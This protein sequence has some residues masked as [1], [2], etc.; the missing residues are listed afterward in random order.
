MSAYIK[1]IKALELFKPRTY[2]LRLGLSAEDAAYSLGAT[3][4][5]A[6]KIQTVSTLGLVDF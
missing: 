3:K 4:V 5:L 2:S 1:V 6:T